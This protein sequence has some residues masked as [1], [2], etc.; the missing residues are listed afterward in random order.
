M[1][2]AN[3]QELNRVF[4]KIKARFGDRNQ[5]GLICKQ[6]CYT[7][8]CVLKLQK[9][10]WTNDPMDQVQNRSGIFFSVWS[11]EDSLRQRR[12]IYDIHAL[13]LRQ[14]EG[15]AITSRD[16]ARDFRKS[17]ESLRRDWPNVS[18]DYGP[19]TLMK[20]WIGSESNS[21]Q[22][23]VLIMMERFARLS[24]LIDGLL[25]SRRR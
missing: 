23:D 11:N 6:G 1:D 7:G 16:F 12:V 9:A 24:P 4:A 10:L 14:L 17:F 21:L 8:C 15:Y 19:L 2:S 5:Y 20:G 3:L 25:E 13:K 18:V 22:E